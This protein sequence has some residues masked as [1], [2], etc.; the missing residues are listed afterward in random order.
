MACQLDTVVIYH[1]N[2]PDGLASAW[3]FTKFFNDHPELKV[4]YVAA[5]HNDPPP[6]VTNKIVYIV[7]FSYNKETTL[8]MLGECAKMTLLDH[9]KTALPLAD[10]THPNFSCVFDMDRSGCQITWDYTRG[11]WTNLEKVIPQRPWFLDDIADR[12]IWKWSIPESKECTTAMFASGY[13]ESMEK[14]DTLKNANRDELVKYGKVLLTEREKQI[15]AIANR[16]VLCATIIGECYKVKIVECD[17]SFASDV[18]DYLVQN[19]ETCDFAVMFRYIILKDEWWCS[20]R[21]KNVDLTTVVKRFDPTAGGHPKASGFT[22]RNGM[23]L[24]TY[25]VPVEKY[26]EDK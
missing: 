17:H 23:N 9:H 15:K 1:K 25:F 8:K 13:Y 14:F 24:R 3:C 7:D 20:A 19:D 26:I 6:D 12:D 18:G 16:A 11:M 10:I 5:T 2:C 4:E 22:L 21:S